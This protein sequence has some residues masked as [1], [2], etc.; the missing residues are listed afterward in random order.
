MF[1]AGLLVQALVFRVTHADSMA[2]YKLFA[3]RDKLIRLV[4]LGQVQRDEPHLDRLYRDLNTL[5]H[6]SRGIS[7]PDGWPR[8][9]ARGR[10]LAHAAGVSQKPMRMRIEDFPESLRPLTMELRTALQH[11]LRNHHGVYLQIDAGRREAEKVR[12]ARAKALLDCM[13]ASSDH[14]TACQN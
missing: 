7:G 14:G 3:V 9:T 1:M 10:D 4:V 11:L 5:L 6:S 13:P 12:R 8:A 2:T